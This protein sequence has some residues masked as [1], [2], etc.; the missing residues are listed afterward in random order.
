MFANGVDGPIYLEDANELTAWLTQPPLIV[1]GRIVGPSSAPS[2]Y[3][4]VDS[5][6]EKTIEENEDTLNTQMNMLMG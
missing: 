2:K 6:I 4:W 5:L 3:S 1:D